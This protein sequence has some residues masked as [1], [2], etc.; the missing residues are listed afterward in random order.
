MLFDGRATQA[1]HRMAHQEHR[2]LRTSS[3][4][5]AL[6][7]SPLDV[8]KLLCPARVPVLL[9]RAILLVGRCPAKAPLVERKD[10]NS[11]IGKGCMNV[12]MAC[13]VLVKSVDSNK[14]GFG[15]G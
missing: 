13:D 1:Y 5:P 11:A 6:F 9:P 8:L 7:D 2:H 10:C 14:Q 3:H 15:S 12:F 4:S